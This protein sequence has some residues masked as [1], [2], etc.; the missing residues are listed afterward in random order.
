MLLSTD[1]KNF[2]AM[3]QDIAESM[4]KKGVEN[5]DAAATAE[6][7][8]K[9]TVDGKKE[10]AESSGAAQEGESKPAEPAQD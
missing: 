10:E 4:G 7:L 3:V 9:L 2:M 6:L 5:K 1:C 8:D